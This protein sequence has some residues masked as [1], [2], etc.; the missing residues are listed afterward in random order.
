MAKVF[1]LDELFD[2]K[3]IDKAAEFYEVMNQPKFLVKDTGISYR[4]INHWDSMG[5]IRCSRREDGA[6]DRKFS[7][8]DLFWVKIVEELRA[9][10]VPVPFIKSI[11]DDIYSP[12]PFNEILDSVLQVPELFDRFEIENK[13]EF[14]D[15]IQSDE[16]KN[17]D[18]SELKFSFLHLFIVD[19]IVSREPAALIVFKNGE[20]CPYNPTRAQWYPEELLNK[21]NYSSHINISLIDIAFQF[22]GSETASRFLR[23]FKL[24]SPKEQN[25]LNIIDSGNYKKVTVLYKNKKLK[26]EEIKKGKGAKEELI[27]IIRDKHYRDFIISDKKGK[28][29]RIKEE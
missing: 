1:Q 23:D 29:F 21:V 19:A 6:G 22:L 15:T 11:T 18:F 25:L 20:W 13:Q 14:M 12:V 17:F 3:S 4:N 8:M 7:F 26:P 27:K 24:L 16:F 9:F 2:S 10:G 5:L 28:E